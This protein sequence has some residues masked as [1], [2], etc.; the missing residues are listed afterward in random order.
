M[1]TQIRT[2]N[3]Y[4]SLP[5]LLLPVRAACCRGQFECLYSEVSQ[6]TIRRWLLT[7]VLWRVTRVDYQQTVFSRKIVKEIVEPELSDALSSPTD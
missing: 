2:P 7:R 6:R 5:D 1:K 3:L 4:N